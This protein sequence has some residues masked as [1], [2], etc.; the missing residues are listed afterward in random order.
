MNLLGK[1]SPF[2]QAKAFHKGRERILSSADFV[3]RWHV[4]YWYPLDFTFICPT[5]LRGFEALMPTF[6][7]EG[8]ALI[9]AS[10]DSVYAHKAW[11]SDR[12]TF[13]QDI[14]HPILAD[15]THAVSKAFGVLNEAEGV[16]YRATVIIDDAGIVRG[17]TM[18]DTTVG[19]SPRETLRTIQALMSGGLCGADWKRGDDFVGG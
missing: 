15:T 2:W 17:L 3:G 13:P 19:R 1:Q 6:E 16:P 5:E 11:F 10:T 8:I 12:I 18:Y 4:I 14:T 7:D 9:G